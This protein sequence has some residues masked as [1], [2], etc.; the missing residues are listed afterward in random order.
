MLV[1][2]SL[3]ACG[4]GNSSSSQRAMRSEKGRVEDSRGDRSILIPGLR[5]MK[6]CPKPENRTGNPSFSLVLVGH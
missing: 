5:E 4:Y 2:G 1:E 3:D 6:F